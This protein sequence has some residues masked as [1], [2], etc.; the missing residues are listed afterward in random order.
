M[1]HKVIV[2]CVNLG[3]RLL[4]CDTCLDKL[5]RGS[6]MGHSKQN[7]DSALCCKCRGGELCCLPS[8]WQLP[9]FHL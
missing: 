7:A 8:V 5:M 2:I 6:G 1:T 3:C 9:S 4:Y